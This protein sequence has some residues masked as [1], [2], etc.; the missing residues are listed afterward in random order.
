M[1]TVVV[2][3]ATGYLG[4]FIVAELHRQGHEVRAI[5]RDQERAELP[6]PWGSPALVGM[7]N[8]WAV[9]NVTDPVFAADVVEG[10]S[11]VISAL[12]V[13]RQK[14][15]PWDVDYRAN[16]ALL[17]S[18]LHHQVTSFCYVNVLGGAECPARLTQ[19]KAAF[20]RELQ[21]ADVV[22]QVINPSGYFSDMMQILA[23][24]RRGRVFL[25]DPHKRVHP[26]H[27]ADLARVCVEKQTAGE[28]D[29]G[30]PDV[31]TWWELAECAFRAVHKP[32]KI[33]VLPRVVGMLLAQARWSTLG[34][35]AWNMMH[36]SVGE[37]VGSHKLYDFYQG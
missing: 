10:A 31:F 7:V 18:A 30:G 24:A 26:I 2:A 29:V 19:A 23:M 1:S 15:N 11:R 36:D 17:Q 22:S 25:L 3:G 4:R 14:A 8:E 34:F 9:G 33:T 12:G 35:A 27:G 21:A 5:V 32:A 13:T 6:G 20:V 28:W 37:S 16:L